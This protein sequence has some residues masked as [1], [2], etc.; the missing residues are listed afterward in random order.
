MKNIQG[1]LAYT[2]LTLKIHRTLFIYRK[3]DG[4]TPLP[5]ACKPTFHIPLYMYTHT[6]SYIYNVPPPYVDDLSVN[7]KLEPHWQWPPCAPKVNCHVNQMNFAPA[8]PKCIIYMQFSG[9]HIFLFEGL[10]QGYVLLHLMLQDIVIL[11]YRIWDKHHMNLWFGGERPCENHCAMEW[12]SPI[13]WDIVFCYSFRNKWM[14]IALSKLSTSNQNA[15]A[16]V[17]WPF[18]VDLYQVYV[19]VVAMIKGIVSLISYSCQPIVGIISLQPLHF[20]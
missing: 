18:H 8:I 11:L 6:V 10:L 19:K 9:F 3:L 16:N 12:S 2:C 7:Q 13:H 17:P 20:N 14:S 15:I 4:T 1:T 5:Y